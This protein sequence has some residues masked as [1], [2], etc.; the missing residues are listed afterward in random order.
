MNRGKPSLTV[1]INDIKLHDAPQRMAAS[2]ILWLPTLAELARTGSVISFPLTRL[3]A[4]RIPLFEY[5]CT[6]SL[7]NR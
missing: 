5:D 1:C 6:T 3:P 7:N 2:R 4:E